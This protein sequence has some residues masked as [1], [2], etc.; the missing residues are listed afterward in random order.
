MRCYNISMKKIL[1]LT[2]LTVASVS[3]A[4]GELGRATRGGGGRRRKGPADR[5][6]SHPGGPRRPRELPSWEYGGIRLVA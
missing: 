2:T 3:E 4:K 6:L 1:D 5:D